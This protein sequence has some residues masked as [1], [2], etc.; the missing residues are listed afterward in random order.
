MCTCGDVAAL[1]CRATA[2]I[3]SSVRPC[4]LPLRTMHMQLLYNV[5]CTPVSYTWEKKHKNDSLSQHCKT[6]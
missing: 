6:L 5:C 2:L 4:L 1:H 3:L